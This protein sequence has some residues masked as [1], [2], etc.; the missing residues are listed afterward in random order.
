MI[1][2][3]LSKYHSSIILVEYYIGRVLLCDSHLMEYYGNSQLLIDK[4]LVVEGFSQEPKLN[5]IL[6]DL[7]QIVAMCTIKELLL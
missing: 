7:E 3:N 4:N 5:L 1:Q 2:P 6:C